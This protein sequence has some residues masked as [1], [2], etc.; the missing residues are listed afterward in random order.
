MFELR[1][2]KCLLLALINK[3]VFFRATVFASA[4]LEQ[5][6]A[7]SL[8]CLRYVPSSFIYQSCYSRLLPKV[9]R[10]IVWFYFF[11]ICQIKID[12]WSG[13]SLNVG[14]ELQIS[15]TLIRIFSLSDLPLNSSYF[16]GSGSYEIFCVLILSF[17]GCGL[18]P[19]GP[20]TSNERQGVN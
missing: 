6:I 18:N 2:R 17:S 4:S 16:I 20:P 19:C 8:V 7:A 9:D 12:V 13:S 15:Y 1:P 11:Y 3:I 5:S 10:R 14:L